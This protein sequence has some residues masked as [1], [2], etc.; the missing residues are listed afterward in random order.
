MNP[1]VSSPISTKDVSS[2]TRPRTTTRKIV[3]FF[4][5]S[6]PLKKAIVIAV[7]VVAGSALKEL[8]VVPNTLFSSKNNPL[9]QYMVKL[10]WMWTLLFLLAAV[11]TTAPLYSALEWKMT[12]HFLRVGVGHF[13][14]YFGTHAITLLETSAGKCSEEEFTTRSTCTRAGYVWVGL[15]ISGHAF[16][17]T[18]CILVITEEAANIKLELWELFNR[19]T[20]QDEVLNKRP[21]WVGMWIKVLYN[22]ANRVIV[23]VETYGLAL[24]LLWAVMLTAT[25]LY[26]HSFT[27]KVAGYFMAVLCWYLT[28]E[29]LYGRRWFLPCKPT[30]GA[31][32]PSRHL[33]LVG[34]RRSNR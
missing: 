25:A 21:T 32:H 20:L 1:V 22:I 33:G 7:I 34:V 12:R 4:L 19:W 3:N 30:A 26:F 18:Y 13:I 23:V 11:T 9:N 2:V 14:W 16:L 10:S 24:V 15:D 27:E 31:L 29:L 8:D 6:S 17:L 28:Y 5:H